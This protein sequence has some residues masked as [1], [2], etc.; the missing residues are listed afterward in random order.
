[1]TPYKERMT[2]MATPEEID[3]RDTLVAALGK[4]DA[5]AHLTL[6]WRRGDGYRVQR[7]ELEESVSTK[8]LEYAQTVAARLKEREK[9]DYDPEWPLKDHEHFELT[10]SELPG[11]N[12]FPALAGFHNLDPFKKKNLAKP[13]LYV[14]AIQTGDG[15]ALFGRRMARLKVLKK[16]AGIFAATWDGSTFN[17][18]DNSVA[19]FSTGFDWVYWKQTLYIL[20]AVAF[21]AEFRDTEALKDAVAK[22]MKSLE[23]RITINNATAMTERCRRNVPMASKLKRI[24][25]TGLHLTSTP[26]DLQDYAKRYKIQVKW[27]GEALVFDGSLEGQWAILKL[28]DEDRTEGPVS[29]RHFESAA[30]RQI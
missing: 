14:V 3:P 30:K 10:E 4:D 19:T 9:L 27:E 21:H 2:P 25:E 12:L 28:L 22:H 15:Q 23:G 7:V 13:R 8:F 1:M 17:E 26:T 6:A 29:G 24:S 18:L 5:K 11:G 20:D 16:T